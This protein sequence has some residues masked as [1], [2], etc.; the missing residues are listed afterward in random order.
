MEIMSEG[1]NPH[2]DINF[3]FPIDNQFKN[4]VFEYINYFWF[5]QLSGGEMIEYVEGIRGI[6]AG[7]HSY[8]FR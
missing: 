2:L 8:T 5:Q 6:A 7:E 3:N 4:L 1:N